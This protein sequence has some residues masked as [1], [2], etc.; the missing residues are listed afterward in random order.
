MR[1]GCRGTLKIAILAQFLAIEPHF[2]RKGCR[3]G[4]KIERVAFRAVSLALPRAFKREIEK[5][6][7]ARGQESKRA[8]EN[9]K[10]WRCEDENMRRWGDV[11]IRW[12]DEQMWRWEDVKMWGCEDVRMW[13]CEDEKM[14][15]CEDVKMRRRGDEQMW[16]WDDV[17]VFDRPPLLEEPFAQTLSGKTCGNQA[18]RG[19]NP[20]VRQDARKKMFYLSK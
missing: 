17:K 9:V 20:K 16:R 6:E 14:W 18:R 11:K 10:M 2:V 19:S 1:K 5:K 4:C 15:R 8:R 12:E 7:R 3:R 13:G